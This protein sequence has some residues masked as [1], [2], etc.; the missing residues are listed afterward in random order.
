MSPEEWAAKLD[1]LRRSL[2]LRMDREGRWYHEGERF[3]HPR[4][5][6]LFDR[7]VDAHPESGEPI[8]HIGDKWCYFTADD[9]PFIV[10]RLAS[11]AAG[12]VAH[13]NNEEAHPIPAA[14]FVA[15]GD[16]IY[17]ALAPNRRARLDRDSQNQLWKWLDAGPPPE[18]V[19]PA[20]RW[21]IRVP[22]EG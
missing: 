11:T 18:V 1:Q 17:V 10:R 13:L 12:L 2:D 14:G 9:T 20:G 7:G 4:L 3:E 21:P 22:A 6:A 19:T 16:F 15:E 8:V 5:I